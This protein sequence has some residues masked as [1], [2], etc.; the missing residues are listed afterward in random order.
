MHFNNFN[1]KLS[2]SLVTRLGRY[3]A[4]SDPGF[5]ILENVVTNIG[6]IR[7]LLWE[8]PKLAVGHPND[9]FLKTSQLSA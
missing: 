1:P 5:K 6:L 3:K 9:S 4:L 7:L 2:G 8:Y